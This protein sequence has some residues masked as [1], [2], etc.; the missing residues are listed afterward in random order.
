MRKLYMLVLAA[1][2]FAFSPADE[3]KELNGFKLTNKEV[4]LTDFNLWV[5]TTPEVFCQTFS[6]ERAEAAAPD[7]DQ[8][9]VL[10]GKLRTV[11]GFYSIKFKRTVVSKDALNVYFKIK[12]DKNQVESD[13]SVS[14]VLV[15]RNSGVKKVNFYHDEVLVRTVPIVTVF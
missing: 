9:W 6:P 8:E 7:F 11:S 5:I 4:S 13:E 2:L 3:V 14:M 1:V 12:R 10:A 15:P